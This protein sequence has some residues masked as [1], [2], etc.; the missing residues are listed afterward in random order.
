GKEDNPD[1]PF[2]NVKSDLNS[3]SQLTRLWLSRH[4][5]WGS[6]VY[7]VG[8]SYGGFRAAALAK[9][10]AEDVGIRVSGLVLVS[11]ALNTAILH[12]DVSNVMAAAFELPSF[13]ATAAVL[14][15]KSVVEGKGRGAA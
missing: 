15:R 5:R 4:Q 13:A 12:P 8:E 6:P 10:L 9:N 11:P 14:D 1:K 3:L 7:L 2:W